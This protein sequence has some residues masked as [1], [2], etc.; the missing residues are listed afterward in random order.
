MYF[1][2]EKSLKTLKMGGQKLNLIFDPQNVSLFDEQIFLY[3]SNKN[4]FFK[5][6]K[7]KN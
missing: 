2:R 5:K 6:Y 3:P 4:L 1:Y 7:I